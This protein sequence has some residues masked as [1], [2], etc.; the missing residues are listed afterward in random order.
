MINGMQIKGIMIDYGG[1]IDASGDHWSE[2]ICDGYK[3]A[4]ISIDKSVFRGCYVEAERALASKRLIYPWHNFMDLMKIKISL[5]FDFLR[6]RGCDLDQKLAEKVARYC[7]DF[8]RNTIESVRPVL[9][10]LSANYKVALISNFY[11]NIE[12]VLLD[13]GIRG[14]FSSIVESAVVGVRKPDPRIF[15]IGCVALNLPP[16]NILVIGDSY[17]KDIMPALSIGCGAVW[18]KGRPWKEGEESNAAGVP[19]IDTLSGLQ[20]LMT[21]H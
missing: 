19:E 20:E 17:K 12:S 9:S 3:Y 13:F 5:E 10:W 2:I 21:E 6:N 11:G 16:E 8:A 4:G 15:E 7:Y 18:I 1:T 14:Y